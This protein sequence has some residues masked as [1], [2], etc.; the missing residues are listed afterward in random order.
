MPGG[1][2]PPSAFHAS[3]MNDDVR[4]TDQSGVL[5]WRDAQVRIAVEGE[6]VQR[7]I[8]GNLRPDL[9]L[10]REPV[11]PTDTGFEIRGLGTGPLP[12]QIVEIFETIGNVIERPRAVV[13]VGHRRADF[14]RTRDKRR[15]RALRQEWRVEW[16]V[17]RRE[18][19]ATEIEEAGPLR[20]GDKRIVLIGNVLLAL[21]IHLERDMPLVVELVIVG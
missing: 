10:R 9:D 11:L 20:V 18:R 7:F 2:A 13:Y 14:R 5:V 19:R 8:E 3:E 4:R 21:V 15:V 6:A 16:H 17:L 12:F 1:S